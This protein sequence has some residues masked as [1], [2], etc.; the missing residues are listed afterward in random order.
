MNTYT[1]T[2]NGYTLMCVYDYEAPQTETETDPP[3]EGCVTVCEIFVNGSTHD[4]YELINPA[5]IQQ[6]ESDIMESL[7]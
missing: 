2:E 5:I 6:I 4:A 1:H 3:F 7:Q